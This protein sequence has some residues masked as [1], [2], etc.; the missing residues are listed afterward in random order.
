[1]KIFIFLGLILTSSL[2]SEDK[3]PLLKELISFYQER[4]WEQFHS[5]K[6]LAMDLAAETGELVELFRWMTE[7]QSKQLDEKTTQEIRGEIGDIY[8]CIIYLSYKL[9]IDP[10]EATYEK[11]EKMKQKYP[12]EACRGKSLKYTAYEGK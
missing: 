4:D 7:E 11:L 9:G 3:D 8:K 10:V 5:P 12:A 2:Y 6:N 1:M